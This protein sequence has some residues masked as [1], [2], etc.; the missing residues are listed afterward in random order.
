MCSSLIRSADA[1]VVVRWKLLFAG[2]KL[3]EMKYDDGCWKLIDG[4]EEGTRQDIDSLFGYS[5]RFLGA[6]VEAINDGQGANYRKA[7]WRVF[8]CILRNF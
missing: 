8:C 1:S 4:D 7:N 6:G 3:V 5:N 2:T